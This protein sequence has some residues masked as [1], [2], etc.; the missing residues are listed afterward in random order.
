MSIGL[1]C[2]FLVLCS[3][4]ILALL[5]GESRPVLDVGGPHQCCCGV[6]F[7]EKLTGAEFTAMKIKGLSPYFVL[8]SLLFQAFC[9]DRSPLCWDST[10]AK[11]RILF[12]LRLW[13]QK[14]RQIKCFPG[15]ASLGHSDTQE[16]LEAE[17]DSASTLLSSQPLQSTFQTG[18]GSSLENTH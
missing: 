18:S 12:L 9:L 8:S 17:P 14:E 4:K 5:L 13:G 16:I 2:T 11:E 7:R 10:S 15:L 1:A 3:R 6:M